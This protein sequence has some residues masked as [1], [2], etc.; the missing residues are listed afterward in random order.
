MTPPAIASAGRRD[1]G[2]LLG[3]RRCTTVPGRSRSSGSRRGGSPFLACCTR[4]D[5]QPLALVLALV[6]GDRAELACR[7]PPGR[8]GQVPHA[9]G[10]GLV[11]DAVALTDADVALELGGAAVQTVRVPGDHR[12]DL[13][14]LDVGEHAL[15]VG[16]AP[17]GVGGQVVVAVDL[18]DVPAEALRQGAALLFLAFDAEAGAAAVLADTDVNRG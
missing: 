7:H 11:V 5:L 13:P 4:A 15:V 3:E 16:A 12:G 2:G 9:R 14:G 10:D 6:G 18:G 1:L 8:R 17:S